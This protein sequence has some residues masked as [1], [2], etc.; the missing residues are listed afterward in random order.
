LS[1]IDFYCLTVEKEKEE[2]KPLNVQIKETTGSWRRILKFGKQEWKLYILGFVFLL[3]AALGTTILFKQK[4]N[5]IEFSI[6]ADMFQPFFSGHIISSVVDRDGHRF[7]ISIFWY[8]GIS[9]I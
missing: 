5:Q 8:L 3:I 2:D 1:I 6:L 7:L 4:P 9:V